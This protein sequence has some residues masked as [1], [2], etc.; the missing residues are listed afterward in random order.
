MFDIN[1]DL[2]DINISSIEREDIVPIQRWINRQNDDFKYN[3]SPLGLKDFYERFLE[4]YVSEGEFF[5]KINK[6]DKLVGVLKG[7]IEF[8]NTNEVWLW[9]FM[10]DKELRSSGIGSRII[11]EV[12]RY[13]A[14]GFGIYNFYTGICENDS[15][16]LRFWSRNNFKL[17]RVSKNFFNINDQ[18]LDM[19][20]L[21][22]S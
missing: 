11:E 2:K 16:A 15:R 22:H 13:F 14:E 10:I 18:E 20:V 7:R 8:K 1:I 17:I 12:R 4:Y 3:E 21:K 9:Y 6:D 19:L 5:L